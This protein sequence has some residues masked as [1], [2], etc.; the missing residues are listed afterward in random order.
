MLALLAGCTFTQSGAD[1]SAQLSPSGPCYAFNLV[2]G[3]VPGDNAELHAAFACLNRQGMVEPLVPVDVALDAPTRSG[4][5]GGALVDV[6]SGLASAQ[7]GSAAGILSGLLGAFDDR[8]A[9]E[10]WLRLAVEL[11]YASSVEELGGAVSINSSASLDNGLLV[12]LYD[13]ASATATAVLNDDLTA[14][15]PV[16]SAL[17]SDATP[18]WL[19]TF[20]LL[21][22]APDDDLA[23]LAEEWPAV[24]AAVVDRTADTSNDE[25]PGATGNSLRDGVVALTSDEALVDVVAAAAPLLEDEFTRDQLAGWVIDEDHAGRWTDLD[26]GL[27]YLASVDREGNVASAGADTALVSLVR[28]FHDANQPITC[29]LDLW[30][31]DLEVDLGNL[32]VAILQNLSA[33]DP[34]T[35]ASGV[36]LL[37]DTLGYPLTTAVLDSVAESGVCPVIDEQLVADLESIDRLSDPSSEGLLR[38]L[39]GFLAAADDHIDAVADVA[40]Q[41]HEHALVDPLEEVL[42]D[43]AGTST[44]RSLLAAVPALVDPDGRQAASAFP[45]GVRPV[46]M[47]A[48]CELLVAVA[49]A[50]T[51]RT[52]SPIVETVV[53]NPSTWEA[54]ANSQHL[55]TQQGTTTAD[56]LVLLYDTLNADPEL[57][58]LTSTATLIEDPSVVRPALELVEND[59]LQSALVNTELTRIGPLPWIA[60]LYVG[61]T[62]G[63]LWDT[64]ALFR[65]LLGDSDV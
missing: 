48:M 14:L 32:A 38:S 31:T 40:G 22:Q 51:W 45:S 9:T 33:V 16:S 13:V 63:Q 59:A 1:W 10:R 53:A 11:A 64:L 23:A 41:L 18:R 21:D 27:L 52:L 34:D 56:T 37:G 39:L 17:R 26:D 61:G 44:L 3:V 2:D 12:P 49:D 5:V 55:L 36:D 58:W 42:Y 57:A 25:N 65:P 7:S 15:A 47:G 19:W 29:T 43:L 30:V 62:V 4:N 20:A 50:G 54:V 6:L 24:V 28:L 46:D 35:A 8:A 60:Q